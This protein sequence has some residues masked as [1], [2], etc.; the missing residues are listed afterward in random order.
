MVSV[1]TLVKSAA[2]LCSVLVFVSAEKSDSAFGACNIITRDV[3]VL[4][5]GSSGTYSAI[6]L[7]DSGKS[8]VVVEQK[9]TLGG[10]TETYVDPSTNATVDYGVIY[11][12]TTDIVKTYFERLNVSY[13][14]EPATNDIETIYYDFSKGVNATS[15][16][17]TNVEGALMKYVEL[18]AKYSYIE[19]GFDLE[20]PVPEDLLIPFGLF[21]KKYDIEDLITIVFSFGQGLGNILDQPTLYVF[22]NF[23]TEIVEALQTGFISITSHDT[24]EIYEKAET[25]LGT[26][27]LL[28]SSRLLYVDRTKDFVEVAVKTPNGIKIIHAKK[29]LVTIPPKVENLVSFDLDE[30]E[31]SIFSQFINTAYYT[32]LIRTSGLP[33][34]VAFANAGVDTLYN[35]PPLPGVYSFTPTGISGLLGVKYGSP[36][37]IPDEVVKADIVADVKKWNPEAEVEFAVFSSHSPFELTVPS[38]LIERYFYRDLY[39]LQGHSNTFYTGAAFHTQDSSMLWKFTLEKVLPKII[40]SLE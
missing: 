39:G 7:K 21:I 12:H 6:Q 27:N 4:G 5:G 10:H 13:T 34:D 35:L 38:A 17:A 36:A 31:Y 1:A 40:A 8:V 11:F 22:K 9:D 19:D 30:T 23:G 33:N 20:Y 26:E 28:L 18:L 14:I 3:I 15:Y 2:A 32:S 16:N 25:V 37:I 24:H 29:I